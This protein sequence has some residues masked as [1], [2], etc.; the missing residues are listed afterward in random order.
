MAG[1]RHRN[2][3]VRSKKVRPS[4]SIP[5]SEIRGKKFRVPSHPPEFVPVP[6]YNL[7]VRLPDVTDVTT[8]SLITALRGQLNLG[9]NNFIQ[10]RIINVRIWGPLVAMNSS[11]PLSQLR[12]S[13]WALF[14]VNSTTTGGTFSIQEECL[15][16]PDQVRRAAVGYEYP[17]AQQQIV[18]NQSSTQPIFHLAYG[19][20]TGN[21]TYIKLLWRSSAT[22]FTSDHVTFDSGSGKFIYDL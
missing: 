18:F 6:W 13:F 4:T 10:I 9:P 17:L 2:R 22:V 20:G 11:A 8:S 12:A 7:I 15:D 5:K 16:Y 3:R 21:V 14:P 1:K 19:G